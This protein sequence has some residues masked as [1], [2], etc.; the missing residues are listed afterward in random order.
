M[1]K[2][3]KIRKLINY[4]NTSN[5]KFDKNPIMFNIGNDEVILYYPTNKLSG[6]FIDNLKDYL[7]ES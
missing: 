4:L 5:I 6:N 1:P 7:Y 2:V 3:N